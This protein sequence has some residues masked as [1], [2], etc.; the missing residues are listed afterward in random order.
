MP[1][2]MGTADRIIRVIL[3]A[4]VGLLYWQGMIG[5]TMAIVLG[6]LATIFVLTSLVSFCPIYALLGLSTR[7]EA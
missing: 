3:A 5:G 2:N 7:K 6:V 4:L 1:K